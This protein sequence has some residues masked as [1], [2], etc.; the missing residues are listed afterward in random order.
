MNDYWFLAHMQFGGQFFVTIEAD[1]IDEALAIF[2]DK[3]PEAV[4][5][6]YDEYEPLDDEYEEV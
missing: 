2:R 4:L 6:D 3:Y 5:D 1:S